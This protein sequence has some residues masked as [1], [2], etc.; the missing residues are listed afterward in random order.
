MIGCNQSDRK[1]HFVAE[2]DE[3]RMDNVAFLFSNSS[4][5]SSSPWSGIRA[6]TN[7]SADDSQATE[8]TDKSECCTSL[9]KLLEDLKATLLESAKSCHPNLRES[10]ITSVE[11]VLNQIK[12]RLNEPLI[13]ES[14]EIQSTEGS[15]I[16]S[17]SVAS[18]IQEVENSIKSLRQ[19]CA[20]S[21]HSGSMK[22]PSVKV[23]SLEPPGSGAESTFAVR[24]S[25]GSKGST[26]TTSYA[27]KPYSSGAENSQLSPRSGRSPSRAASGRFSRGSR[28]TQESNGEELGVGRVSSPSRHSN[29]S[30]PPA[31]V[32]STC[33]KGSTARSSPNRKEVSH[34][35]SVEHDQDSVSSKANSEPNHSERASRCPEK[36]RTSS[37][38]VTRE[39]RSCSPSELRNS[40]TRA[41]KTETVDV[42]AASRR[43]TVLSKMMR[44]LRSGRS[45][46]SK[47]GSSIQDPIELCSRLLMF[48]ANQQEFSQGEVN[49]FKT[50]TPEDLYERITA[51]GLEGEEFLKSAQEYLEECQLLQSCRD[52]FCRPSQMSGSLISA[53][54]GDE[55]LPCRRSGTM[56]SKRGYS[57][58]KSG[59]R[60]K[61]EDGTIMDMLQD[62]RCSMRKIENMQE[63]AKSQMI[64]E[65][66]DLLGEVRDGMYSPSK[67]SR[68]SDAYD[69]DQFCTPSVTRSSLTPKNT[70][71]TFKEPL[72]EEMDYDDCREFLD[73][74]VS[75]I[76]AQH[77]RQSG[78]LSTCPRS[79]QRSKFNMRPPCSRMAMD[80]PEM[81]IT[82]DDIR[83][84]I[85]A[86]ECKDQSGPSPEVLSMLTEVRDSIKMLSSAQQEAQPPQP[87]VLAA[88]EEIRET[89]NNV[90]E[91]TQLAQEQANQEMMDMLDCV[92]QSIRSV[93]ASNTERAALKNQQIVDAL[94][95]MRQSVSRLEARSIASEKVL[96]PKVSN[97]LSDIRSSIRCMESAR[98]SQRSAA[99]NSMMNVLQDI[100]QSLVS[101]EGKKNLTTSHRPSLNM[102]VLGGGSRRSVNE[103]IANSMAG[104]R[105][106]DNPPLMGSG[107]MMPRKSS[108]ICPDIGSFQQEEPQRLSTVSSASVPQPTDI[109]VKEALNDIR[110]SMRQIASQKS[111]PCID[112]IDDKR[113]SEVKQ[114]ICE[115]KQEMRSLLEKQCEVS[116]QM[117]SRS[118][119]PPIQELSENVADI[120][121]GMKSLIDNIPTIVDAARVDLIAERPSRRSS[122]PYPTQRGS[123]SE[124]EDFDADADVNS[125]VC[126]KVLELLK[127]MKKER[128][129][130]KEVLRCVQ[131][132]ASAPKPV[133]EPQLTAPPIAAP[134]IAAPPPT[135]PP[136]PL[137]TPIGAPLPAPLAPPLT[138]YGGSLS[139]P[140]AAMWKTEPATSIKSAAF[141]GS[142][143][144]PPNNVTIPVNTPDQLPSTFTL[145]FIGPQPQPLDTGEP[146]IININ[147]RTFKCSRM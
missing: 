16:R 104:I 76:S 133:A 52:T 38:R 57:S 91:R 77:P 46:R 20:A 53:R 134:S 58:I 143:A 22:S 56:A 131:S 23:N 141:S 17:S 112:S 8:E 30:S 136:P 94:N 61:D 12:S 115:L 37:G 128:A 47:M 60:D 83:Q 125:P 84:S 121:S 79:T 71:V 72:E 3:T 101:I 65:V 10:T 82:L 106:M 109:Y 27:T 31:A 144:Q 19:S 26:H 66:D 100:K 97:L 130:E 110:Q 21:R 44:S 88:L 5:G 137:T 14:L 107:S 62:L 89:I 120:K 111:A 51:M 74:S 36:P 124:E 28:K 123:V 55:T 147:G 90:E 34:R 142:I 127:E 138:E 140:P 96:N 102:F 1:V 117:S 33:G 64:P 95:E 105:S 63:A 87:E 32:E 145:S 69:C 2:V 48:C 9:I 24:N 119:Y 135:A 75:R 49:P 13:R 15:E 18:V 68:E 103:E 43:S 99:D 6:Q 35:R 78:G 81:Q 113:Y 118:S 4:N 45:S 54:N 86:I 73:T 42:D 116:S 114:S 129:I 80:N 39:S 25:V 29:R 50:C 126:R 93:E 146:L 70:C 139:T 85:Q 98:A 7:C 40:R 92:R 67:I 122:S 11:A 108:S 132:T 41:T 59:D